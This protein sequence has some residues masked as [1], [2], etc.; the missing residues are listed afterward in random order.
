[1]LL[2]GSASGAVFDDRPDAIVCS[3][4]DPTGVLRWDELVFWVSARMR[5]GDTLYKTLTS[6]P[7]VL[8]VD[9]EG[10]IRG[11]NLA[12]CDGRSVSELR[13]EGRTVDLAPR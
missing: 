2:S 5:E 13:A 9:V 8:V 7:V 3:V 4:S 10:R 1:V 12:D 11:R 6:D